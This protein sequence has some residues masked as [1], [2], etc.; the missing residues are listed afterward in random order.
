VGQLHPA[1]HRSLDG[2]HFAAAV[3]EAALEPEHGFATL[4][5]YDCADDEQA[6]RIARVRVPWSVAAANDNLRRR[7]LNNLEVVGEL[8]AGFIS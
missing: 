7:L 8:R 4:S 5:V 1:R 2:L 3:E 6:V